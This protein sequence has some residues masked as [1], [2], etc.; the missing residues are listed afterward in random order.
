MNS[1]QETGSA[2]TLGLES[3]ASQGESALSSQLGIK[4]GKSWNLGGGV[5]L[6][7]SLSASWEH[8]YQ[9][10]QD[11]MTASFGPGSSFT[12][13]GPATG[14]DAAVLGAGVEAQFSKQITLFAQYQGKVGLTDDASSQLSGG[15]NVGF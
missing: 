10:N 8:F 9:G 4:A 13:S 5:R 7:P 6:A 14:S 3:F 15:V 1:F 11:Q 12:V 2:G